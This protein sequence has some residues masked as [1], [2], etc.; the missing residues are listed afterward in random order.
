MF[1]LTRKYL[2]LTLLIS[3]LFQIIPTFAQESGSQFSLSLDVLGQEVYSP[4]NLKTINSFFGV[5]GTGFFDWRLFDYFSVGIGGQYVELPRY[6][7]FRQ[8]KVGSFQLSTL[9]VQG[10]FFPFGS[11]NMGEFYLLGGMGANLNSESRP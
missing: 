7:Y 3:G 9:D 11:S 8:K 5:G 6:L 1:L 2:A 10:R 4:I